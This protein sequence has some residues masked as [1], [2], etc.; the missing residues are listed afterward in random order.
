M[1]K[2]FSELLLG[3][4]NHPSNIKCYVPAFFGDWFVGKEVGLRSG[5]LGD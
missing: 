5:E 2:P 4:T 1:G 3:N